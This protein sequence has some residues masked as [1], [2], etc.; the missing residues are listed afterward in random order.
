MSET[1]DPL[2]RFHW[3]G[4]DGPLDDIFCVSFFHGLGPEDV[5]PRFGGPAP[6]SQSAPAQGPESAPVSAARWMRF[7]EIGERVV[8]SLADSAGA[9]GGYVAVVQTGEWSVAVEPFGWQGTLTDV[10]ERLSADCEFVAV[11]RHDYAEGRFV[12]AVGGTVTTAFIPHLP[13][14][15][16]GSEPAALDGLL[17]ELGVDPQDEYESVEHDIAT[18]FALAAR[19]TGVAFTPDLLEQPMLVGEVRS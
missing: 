2:A 17:R 9:E 3:L 7:D 11:G 5:V 19:V 14:M 16:Y 6:S 13:S 1:A 8:E 18:A 4:G 12:H 15:P 10:A